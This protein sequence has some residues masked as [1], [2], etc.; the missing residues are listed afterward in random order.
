MVVMIVVSLET[1]S[2]L[3]TSYLSQAELPLMPA[4]IFNS[5]WLPASKPAAR[6][7]V[8]PRAPSAIDF[9]ASNSLRVP[10]C[11]IPAARKRAPDLPNDSCGEQSVETAS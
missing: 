6:D 3:N 5:E 2:F 10:D 1:V 4:F 7:G 8:D 9:L 11:W